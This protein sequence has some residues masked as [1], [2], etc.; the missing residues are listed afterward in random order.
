MVIE[1]KEIDGVKY[2]PAKAFYD[3]WKQLS[4]EINAWEACADMLV[5]YAQEIKTTLTS[6][7][8]YEA[9]CEDIKKYKKLKEKNDA[10]YGRKQR[11]YT[12]Y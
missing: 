6:I 10:Q 1:E 2:V 12:V 3:M 5:M 4:E 11:T 7:H 8:L 9:S